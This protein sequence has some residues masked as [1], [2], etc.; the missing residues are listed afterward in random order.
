MF[1]HEK[2]NSRHTSETVEQQRQKGNLK[3]IREKEVLFI[4]KREQLEIR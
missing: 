2:K 1:F 3:V 4:F